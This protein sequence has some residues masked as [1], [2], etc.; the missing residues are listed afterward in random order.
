MSPKSAT[1]A[2][3][4]RRSY[5]VTLGVIAVLSMPL[6][7]KEQGPRLWRKVRP[8]LL[9]KTTVFAPLPPVTPSDETA[10]KLTDMCT[11]LF[12]LAEQNWGKLPDCLKCGQTPCDCN[13]YCLVCK[14]RNVHCICTICPRCG[15]KKGA[16]SC[17]SGEDGV[18]PPPMERLVW[19]L[20]L[21]AVSYDRDGWVAW[22]GTNRL[23]SG[24]HIAMSDSPTGRCGYRVLSVSRYCLWAWALCNETD[25][26]A[27]T[28]DILWPD[29]R[30]VRLMQEQ[31]V[32]RPVGL[33]MPDGRILPLHRSLRFSRTE[34][35]LS[36]ERLWPRGGEF[37]LRMA[38]GT[39]L[40]RVICV[41]PAR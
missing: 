15:L 2:P 31:G 29:F 10:V 19:D 24:T 5:L 13:N 8:M 11:F 27:K 35:S 40:G 28:P 7:F 34:S 36:L 4:L 30:S 12:E 18:T 20:P 23:V 41:L 6:V 9:G 17:G 37:A 3:L 21:H 33:V 32:N 25:V 22:I 16:C 39:V 38:N 1:P 14:K 26:R